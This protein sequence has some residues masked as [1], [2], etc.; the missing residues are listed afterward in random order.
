MSIRISRRWTTE[1]YM[2]MYLGCGFHV[3]CQNAALLPIDVPELGQRSACLGCLNELLTIEE[4]LM[5]LDILNGLQKAPPLDRLL[6]ELD[7]AL[8]FL[9][10]WRRD[11]IMGSVAEQHRE[12]RTRAAR[13]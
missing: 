3:R 9:P 8:S 10:H 13:N 4:F 7:G 11:L 2:N 6:A 12:A 1:G 5:A